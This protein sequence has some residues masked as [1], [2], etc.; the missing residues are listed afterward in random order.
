MEN[1]YLIVKVPVFLET[2][3]DGN[4]VY[5]IKKNHDWIKED[6]FL[7]DF[8][9]KAIENDAAYLSAEELPN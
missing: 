6:M 1:V 9:E 3:S 7:S 8:M 2:Q 4:Q 5:A